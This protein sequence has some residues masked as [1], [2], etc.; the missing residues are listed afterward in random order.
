MSSAECKRSFSSVNN[1][2]L[3]KRKRVSI[4]TYVIVN[5]VG[6]PIQL[7]IPDQPELDKKWKTK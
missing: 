2:K 7:F 6:L 4:R 5:C 1:I 3:S